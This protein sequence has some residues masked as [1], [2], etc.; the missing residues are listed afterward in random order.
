MFLPVLFHGVNCFSKKLSWTAENIR[1]H[2]MEFKGIHS[3]I[4]EAYN[5]NEPKLFFQIFFLLTHNK[6]LTL[7]LTTP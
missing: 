5:K 3:I 7:I 4:I 2:F 1:N 6:N